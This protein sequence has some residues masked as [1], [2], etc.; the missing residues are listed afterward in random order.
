MPGIDRIIL[1]SRDP[2]AQIAFYCRVL[3][4]TLFVDRTVGY[5][6]KGAR[7]SFL[8]AD[9]A[10][11]SAAE[12]LY[13]K[14][15]LAVPDLDLAYRQL[16]ADGITVGEPEQFADIGYLAHFRDPEGFT[17]ELIAHCFQGETSPI[18]VDPERFGGG[19]T[20][21]LLTLRCRSE[22]LIAEKCEG[23]GMK[24][25]A[26]MPVERFGFTLH[27]YAFTEEDPP[28]PDP[29]A[30]ENRSWVYQRPYTVFEVQ[31]R[32]S[33]ERIAQSA[34]GAAGYVETVFEGPEAA[35]REEIFSVRIERA[36]I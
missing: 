14:I 33:L 1:R 16:R 24:R 7:L 30:I 15:A 6:G 18:P 19:A 31:H 27:F 28:S 26:I 21:N 2:Q 17:I 11:E 34:P 9:T 5:P 10:Y 4:M 12:D 13:W 25:L 32:P 36:P 35:D 8:P 3:G 20:L 29:E 22:E 23:W